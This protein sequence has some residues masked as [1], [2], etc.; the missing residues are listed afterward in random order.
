MPRQDRALSLRGRVR[1]RLPH[2]L[3]HAHLPPRQERREEG[4]MG[5]QG[6]HPALS[7]ENSIPRRLGLGGREEGD[8][9]HGACPVHNGCP[10]TG[11]LMPTAE[12][13]PAEFPSGAVSW[14]VAYTFSCRTA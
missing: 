7:Q 13:T 3:G 5:R 1:T 11:V 10:E 4:T 6:L 14:L 9:G 12:I 2:H 8:R